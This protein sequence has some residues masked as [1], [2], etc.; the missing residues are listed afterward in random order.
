LSK[1]TVEKQEDDRNTGKKLNEGRVMNVVVFLSLVFGT[2]VCVEFGLIL[3]D[4][5]RARFSAQS[6]NAASLSF[7]R[8][9]N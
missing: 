5:I 2:S 3:I 1:G 7:I 6:S 4:L 8:F 9:S